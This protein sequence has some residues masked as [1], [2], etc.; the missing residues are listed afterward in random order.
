MGGTKA[1]EVTWTPDSHKNQ[2]WRRNQSMWAVRTM[3][4]LIL[5]CIPSVYGDSLCPLCSLP[6]TACLPT[7]LHQENLYQSSVTRQQWHNEMPSQRCHNINMELI[8]EFGKTSMAEG[9]K[10]SNT[11]RTLSLLQVAT[12]GLRMQVSNPETAAL[13]K[14]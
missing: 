8:E 11:G 4:R 13:W 14:G 12:K 3:P 9:V 2:Q 7:G 6:R 1:A 5:H 10:D